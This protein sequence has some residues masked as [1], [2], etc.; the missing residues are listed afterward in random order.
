METGHNSSTALF[1]LDDIWFK[2][3]EPW[4]A[5]FISM[6]R[7][8]AA[9]TPELPAPGKATLPVQERF[10]LAQH[11][12][13]IFS[14]REIADIRIEKE[15]VRL[16]LF[17][18]G[19]WGPQGA[20]P[21]SMTEQ[22]YSR[23][24]LHD[25]TLTDFLDIF[26]HRALSQ[27]YRAWFVA[28]DTASLDRSE[29]EG[30]SSYIAHLVGLEPSEF[31][32]S[33]LPTHARLASSAHLVRESRNPEGLVGALRYYFDI[34]VELEE[35]APQWIL[36]EGNEQTQMGNDN[37]ALL[38]G[39]SAILG[40][41]VWDRQHKFRLNL[42]P[43]TFRQYLRFSLWG[44]DLPVLREWVRNFT[45]FEYAW[46]VQLILAAEEVPDAI[47][48]GSHQLGYTAWLERIPSSVPVT[49]MSFEPERHQ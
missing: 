14:P 1:S 26:H 23:T 46:D 33:P 29:D 41:T 25:H 45:G 11:A 15:K 30:F 8:I 32:N 39:E 48:D 28:Q 22:A 34:P 3:D 27:V 16:E 43:L 38:L 49:G 20:M 5:G 7:M 9:R 44:Q 42:G 21:L 40:N 24:E 10:R 13:M 47:L 2:H 37:S 19:V 35:F 12:H 31:A 17:S 4:N 36:L 6:M 18:L